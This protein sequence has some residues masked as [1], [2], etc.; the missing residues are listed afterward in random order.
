[1]RHIDR[2]LK[3]C[4]DP[5]SQDEYFLFS[6]QI[7]YLFYF[8]CMAASPF[9]QGESYV[10]VLLQKQEAWEEI[11]AQIKKNSKW[12]AGCTSR[13]VCAILPVMIPYLIL[14]CYLFVC[15][16]PLLIFHRRKFQGATW[17][18]HKGLKRMC[19]KYSVPC[20]IFFISIWYQHVLFM[21]FWKFIVFPGI[22]EKSSVILPRLCFL[23]SL[24]VDI[25]NCMSTVLFG[26]WCQ[27]F[28]YKFG[29]LQRPSY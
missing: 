4:W 28:N 26:C 6:L 25:G 21:Q 17:K 23:W 15:L 18:G 8:F 14:G 5:S 1:M 11:K 12:N 19:A 7:D 29:W 9:F 2:K 16:F 10:V 22:T 20:T 27:D 3:S 24:Q 13:S